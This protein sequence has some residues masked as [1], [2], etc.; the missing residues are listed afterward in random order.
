[1]KNGFIF[2]AF[3]FFF[4]LF[5]TCLLTIRFTHTKPQTV[6]GIGGKISIIVPTYKEAENIEALAVSVFAITDANNLDA[7]MIVVDDN[8]QDGIIEKVQELK[9]EAKLPIRIIVRKNERGLSSAVIRGFQE[10]TAE[11][12]AV[13]DADLSHPPS[14]LPDLLL[15]VLGDEAD[16]VLGSRYIDG[17][18]IA[19]WSLFRR[20]VSLGAKYLAY[21][22]APVSDPLSG[23]FAL[24]ASTFRAAQALDA[25]G[26]KI[27]LEVIVRSKA[28]RVVEV[29]ILFKDRIRGSSK[30]TTDQYIFYL[31]QLWQL[32]WFVYPEIMVFLFCGLGIGTYSLLIRWSS[33]KGTKI[34]IAKRKRTETAASL[35]LSSID[36]SGIKDTNRGR[37]DDHDDD[38]FSEDR[39]LAEEI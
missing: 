29:P 38:A 22:L 9:V 5:E 12:F 33:N 2:G 36:L 31:L 27:G 15:P 26:F 13:M 10:S 7:E 18:M 34:G 20:I 6:R 28:E 23:F 8:S 35:D 16:I 19:K 4:I 30:L 21:P 1:M 11:V 3:F 24:R 25:M 37:I 39:S 14:S 17:G 32:Y